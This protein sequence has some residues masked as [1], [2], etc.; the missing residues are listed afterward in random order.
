MAGSKKSGGS[1]KAKSGGAKKGGNTKKAQTKPS[2][3]SKTESQKDPVN[4]FWSVI[5]F[6]AGILVFLLT[7]IEG[8]SG[9]YFIHNL[10]RGLFGVS[11]FLV[12]VI[13]VYTAILISMERSQ[14]TVAGR[15]MWGI[16]LTLLCS[17]VV[18][19]M[20]A[21]EAQG[22]SF[23]EKCRYLYESGSNLEGGGLLSALIAWPLLKFFG[24]VGAKIIVCVLLFIFIMLLSNL[25]LFQF[26]GSFTN[27]LSKCIIRYRSFGRKTVYLTHMRNG[28]MMRNRK[29]F[30]LQIPKIM[31]VIRCRTIILF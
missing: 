11:V 14:Q 28:S 24:N 13:L 5:L 23:T 22:S 27:R 3:G 9:W 16:G 30:L 29:L 31:K 8:S 21:G 18:Q 12:P 10:F 19:I 7:V 6:A 20:F 15:A 25:T 4:Q 2:A 26:F 17:S 1:S